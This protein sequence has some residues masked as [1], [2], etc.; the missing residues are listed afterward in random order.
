MLY[1][2]MSYHEPALFMKFPYENKNA[3]E[4]LMNDVA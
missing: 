1:L 2:R 3:V 4:I